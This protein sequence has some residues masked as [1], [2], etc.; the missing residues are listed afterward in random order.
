MEKS[1]PKS[2]FEEYDS[3]EIKFMELSKRMLSMDQYPVD[4]YIIGVINRS[5]SLLYG[6]KT[7]LMSEN[8]IAG[9][10]LV[11]PHLDNFV[12]LYAVWLV[13]NPHDFCMKILSG[14]R[15]DKI[16]DAK[17]NLMRD[18][19]LI[20]KANESYP[21]MLDVYQTTSGFIHFSGKH[22]F[23]SGRVTDAFEGIIEHKI[24]KYDKYVQE[25]SRI[26]GITCM[27]EIT[28]AIFEL[29]EGWIHTKEQNC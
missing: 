5:L 3:L 27:I 6:F 17:S 19:Y 23:T 24:S 10:H 29:I 28:K 13:D 9:A 22:V 14:E 8:F 20:K 1:N 21:W 16:K 4:Y 7:L 15:I 18:S 11:R 12:R 2:I 26:E 25:A